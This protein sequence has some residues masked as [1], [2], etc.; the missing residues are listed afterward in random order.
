MYILLLKKKKGDRTPFP[1]T[2][3]V[4][5]YLA[6]QHNQNDVLVVNPGYLST[7]AN[8]IKNFC[9]KL[10]GGATTNLIVL[11]NKGMN[12]STTVRDQGAKNTI[13]QEHHNYII[14][15][16]EIN[17][18]VDHSKFVFFAERKL[19]DGSDIDDDGFKLFYL[20]SDSGEFYKVK[21]LLLGSSNMSLST[22]FNTRGAD[23]G[24]CDIFLIRD[25]V[26]ADDNE[27]KEFAEKIITALPENTVAREQRVILSKKLTDESSLDDLN[28]Y[29]NI[30]LD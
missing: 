3:A 28:E 11:A 4:Q 8:S 19:P 26:F 2:L 21:A 1:T 5:Q 6:M 30:M 24:E 29:L 25:S 20:L 18:D 27:A 7:T 9:T 16:I 23:K 17:R 12:G 15:G 13:L 14:N 10:F 22:Y